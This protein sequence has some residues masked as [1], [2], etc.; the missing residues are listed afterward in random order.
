MRICLGGAFTKDTGQRNPVRNTSRVVA[1]E[2]CL[3][4]C[5]SHMMQGVLSDL[6]PE[7]IIADTLYELD[8]DYF[9]I[10]KVLED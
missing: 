3:I 8:G 7:V 6:Q 1:I 4:H 2:G 10:Y 5:A 9:G